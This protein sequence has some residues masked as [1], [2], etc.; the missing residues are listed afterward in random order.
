VRDLGSVIDMEAIRGAAIRIA[1][2]HWER[3]GSLLGA[4]RRT[5]RPDLSVVSGIVDPTFGSLT[6][7]WD[8]RIRMDPLPVS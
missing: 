8:R 2:I 5:L 4:D 6:V 7:D 1:S 3:R